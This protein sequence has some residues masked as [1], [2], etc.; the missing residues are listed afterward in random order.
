MSSPGPLPFAPADPPQSQPPLLSVVGVN[1]AAGPDTARLAGQ[2]LA[3][4]TARCGAAEVVIVDTHSPPHRLL[5]RLRRR[6]GVSL[7]RWGRN[8]G[9]GR[10]VNEGVRLSRGGW[11]L[12]LN[13]D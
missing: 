9:F 1:Y 6:R 4:A 3:A 2:L 7:R 13:P 5:A 10:A 11:L 12:L 8:R